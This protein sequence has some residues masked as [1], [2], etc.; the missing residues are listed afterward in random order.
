MAMHNNTCY[1]LDCD[2]CDGGHYD[3]YVPH[4]DS[5]EQAIE[6]AR[7]E[8]WLVMPD[9]LLCPVCA[10]RLDCAVTGHQWTDW[11]DDYQYGVTYRERE[12]LHCCAD[13]SDPPRSQL[14]V[15]LELAREVDESGGGAA[16]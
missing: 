14:R 15:L 5:P 9:R 2:D 8:G 1:W 13:E 6:F 10:A 7:S 4:F 3:D 11:Y 12:C 16:V